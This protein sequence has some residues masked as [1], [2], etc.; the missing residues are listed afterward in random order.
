MPTPK[1][2][3]SPLSERV[4]LVEQGYQLLLERLDREFMLGETARITAIANMDRRLEGMNEFR[5][6]IAE[7]EKKFVFNS[8]LTA[9]EN[10]VD[11][12]MTALAERLRAIETEMAESRSTRLGP[13]YVTANDLRFRAVERMISMAGGGLFIIMIVIKFLKF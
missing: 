8:D 7:A 3:E 4:A 2:S 6:Q 11:A 10:K 12:R 9:V 5:A 13:E 1:C